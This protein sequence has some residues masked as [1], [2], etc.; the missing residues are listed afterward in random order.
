M[1]STIKLKIKGETIYAKNS[2]GV[3]QV[4]YTIDKLFLIK[5]DIIIDEI[6]EKIKNGY[7]INMNEKGTVDFE[8]KT[9]EKFSNIHAIYQYCDKE[10]KNEDYKVRD[11]IKFSDNERQRIGIVVAIQEDTYIVKY[12]SSATV[13]KFNANAFPNDINS[14]IA[15]KCET[16]LYGMINK[17]NVIG[18]LEL[19]ELEELIF[20]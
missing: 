17:N 3:N 14:I 11:I 6:T 7:T 16:G 18:L 1:D 13:F 19:N 4:S 8:L 15:E 12:K 2:K 9:G 20:K 5:D 10:L